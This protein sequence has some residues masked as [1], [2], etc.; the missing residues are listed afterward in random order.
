[1][2]QRSP[3]SI[4]NKCRAYSF[5]QLRKQQATP[6]SRDPAVRVVFEGTVATPGRPAARAGHGGTSAVPATRNQEAGRS[7]IQ[8]KPQRH[9]KL[10]PTPRRNSRPWRTLQSSGYHEVPRGSPTC[11]KRRE[12]SLDAIEPADELIGAAGRSVALHVG[13]GCAVHGVEHHQAVLG[14]TILGGQDKRTL[15]PS[16]SARDRS[17]PLPPACSGRPASSRG[18]AAHSRLL[19]SPSLRAAPR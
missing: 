8:G 5:L 19:R 13:L 9:C 16:S 10:R 18:A 15:K 2:W 1:M 17:S 7:G 6:S 11:P 4:K 3:S 14:S 12:S